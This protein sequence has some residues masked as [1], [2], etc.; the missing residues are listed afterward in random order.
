MTKR[1]TGLLSLGVVLGLAIGS[2][3]Q[4]A[5]P[6]PY[7]DC[8]Y[9][10]YFDKDCPQLRKEQERERRRLQQEGDT[11][12]ASP[13]HEAGRQG[14][15]AEWYDGTAD[16]LDETYLLFPK[17]SLAPD[18]PPLFRLLLGEPTLDNARRYVRWYARRAAR[19]QA[20][21]ALIRLAGSEIESDGR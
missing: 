13:D 7:F 1:L 14:E 19:L 5:A 16:D 6:S 2:H 10:N 18:A 8:P 21:Q 17:E 12:T 4:E 9:V 11:A 3:G 15:Q 20:V